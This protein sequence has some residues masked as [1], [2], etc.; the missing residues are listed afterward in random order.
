MKSLE[1][2]KRFVKG[3]VIGSA[4]LIPGVSGGTTAIILGI[5]D[6]LI[7]SV[8][9]IRQ[10]IKGN[11]LLLLNY[12]LGGLAGILIMSGPLLS[13]VNG[14]PLPSMYFFIGCI[15]ASIP[16]LYRRMNTDKIKFK[17][18]VVALVGALI[19]GALTLLPEGLFQ[20]G[21]HMSVQMFLLLIVAGIII[22]IAL[23][24]PGI[25]G[26]YMLLVFGMYTI[27]LEALKAFD[28][29]FMIPLI[30]GLAIGTF[31]T[32]RILDKQMEKHPQFTY[33]LIIGFMIGSLYQIFPGI[34]T[35]NNIIICIV[36]LIAG[37]TIITLL[38]S[39]GKKSK[40]KENGAK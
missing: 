22:A 15:I 30:I 23:I 7:N 9:R 11:G 24:L 25:S 19:G 18:M 28:I 38:V 33:M 40:T 27:T 2:I 20:V 1:A 36:T 17:N 32:A 16:P 8:S 10:D 5:Y 39:V 4:M 26:S 34:P 21:Q 29:M 14:W 3:F 6:Q 12:G 37:I 31:G 35:G 13:I